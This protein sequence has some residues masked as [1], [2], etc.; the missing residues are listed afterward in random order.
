[1]ALKSNGYKR[2]KRRLLF[3]LMRIPIFKKKIRK[4]NRIMIWSKESLEFDDIV[5]QIAVGL[6][7]GALIMSIIIDLT[8]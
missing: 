3:N 2:W 4:W 8:R 5:T 7:L 1:M 6:I